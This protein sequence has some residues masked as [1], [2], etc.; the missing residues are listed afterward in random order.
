VLSQVCVLS[1][2][3]A[4]LCLLPVSH[5]IPTA[6]ASGTRQVPKLENVIAAAEAVAGEEADRA[7]RL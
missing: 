4:G 7:K 1:C 5:G 6:R 2:E 3:R